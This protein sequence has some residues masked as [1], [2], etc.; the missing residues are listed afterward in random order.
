[1]WDS[2]VSHAT[3][4]LDTG[5]TSHPPVGHLLT[6]G[7]SGGQP[8]RKRGGNGSVPAL[9]DTAHVTVVS[10]PRSPDHAPHAVLPLYGQHLVLG[11]CTVGAQSHQQVGQFLGAE[12][13]TGHWIE[14]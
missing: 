10:L 12:Q 9:P 3:S 8:F 7:R 11:G 2:G 6:P 14:S 4:M 5:G 13:I 1:M